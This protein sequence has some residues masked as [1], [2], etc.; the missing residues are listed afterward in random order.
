MIGGPQEHAL[1]VDLI[2]RAKGLYQQ[3]LLTA[4]EGNLSVRFGGRWVLATPSGR[5]KS[6]IEP[7]DLVLLDL[8]AASARGGA[9]DDEPRVARAHRGRIPSSELQMHLAV[10]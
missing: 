10:V 3:G 9:A 2:R 1:R 8:G 7:K 4:L 6:E 5:A